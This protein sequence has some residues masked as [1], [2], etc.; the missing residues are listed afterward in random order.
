MSPAMLLGTRLLAYRVHETPSRPTRNMLKFHLMA[1]AS[2]VAHIRSHC[3][4]GCVCAP[5]TSTFSSK[6]KPREYLARTHASIFSAPWGS[7]DRNWLQGKARIFRPRGCSSECSSCSSL[8]HVAVLPQK[9]ATLTHRTTLPRISCRGNGF[10]LESAHSRS[11]KLAG[12]LLASQDAASSEEPPMTFDINLFVR[13]RNE[14]RRL[15]ERAEFIA[16]GES[17]M[18]S[19]STSDSDPSFLG[20]AG[21]AG[22][23]SAMCVFFFVV[24]L[25]GFQVASCCR[26]VVTVAMFVSTKVRLRHRR[27]ASISLSQAFL[28]A[29]RK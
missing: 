12:S 28:G 8:Y 5:L 3:Q 13:P 14:K 10:P 27:N 1:L 29:N 16:S 25:C 22:A 2:G 23:V 24:I 4:T 15:A 26:S 7:C 11:K 6:W 20:S 17:G 18:C 9:D 19:F 21:H